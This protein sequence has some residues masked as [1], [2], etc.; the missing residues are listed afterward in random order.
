MGSSCDEMQKRLT[1]ARSQTSQLVGQMGKLKKDKQRIVAKK[2]MAEKFLDKF[3]LTQEEVC[4]SALPSPFF[5]RR[6]IH[7]LV[8]V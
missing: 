6:N 8:G 7:G 3:T 1:E 2:E 5:R 4:A